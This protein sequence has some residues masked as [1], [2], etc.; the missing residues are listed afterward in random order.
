[1][2]REIVKFFGSKRKIMPSPIDIEYL[3]KSI[4]TLVNSKDRQILIIISKRKIKREQLTF[5]FNSDECN[6]ITNW[7]LNNFLICR[8]EGTTIKKSYKICHMYYKFHLVMLKKEHK[9]IFK[10]L[11]EF[12]DIPLNELTF[13]VMNKLDSLL[14]LD[15]NIINATAIM[16]SYFS[17]ESSREKICEYTNLEKDLFLSRTH[18]D[19]LLF[20]K[21]S[22]Q[23]FFLSFD[24]LPDIDELE[25][26]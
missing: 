1:M 2:E 7:F 18:F 19:R 17:K 9:E 22:L 20:L 15:I 24:Y 5:P 4:D 8:D 23:K 13:D 12:E 14:Q 3:I 26:N 6:E 11:K 16:C 25:N 21:Q 10:H